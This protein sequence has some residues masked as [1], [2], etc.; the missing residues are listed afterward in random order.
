M[1]KDHLVST[2]QRVDVVLLSGDLAN[3][4]MENMTSLTT[5]ELE[6][7]HALVHKV[8]SE[9]LPISKHIYF[10]PGNH[11]VITTYSVSASMESP[12]NVHLRC[13]EIA[14]ALHL[15]GAGGSVPGYRNGAQC[16]D[17]FPYPSDEAFAADLT[18]ILDPVFMEEGA[19]SHTDAVILMTHNGP[20]Q[21]STTVA[22]ADPA[23]PVLSGSTALYKALCRQQLQQHVVLNI[24]G[25]T[26]DAPGSTRLGKTAI[27]NPGALVEE[28]YGLYTLSRQ[29]SRVAPAWKLSSITLLNLP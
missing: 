15:V 2:N 29:G 19:L 18:K 10:I 24:H 23:N 3:V 14:P 9:F 27:V 5:L 21:S 4:P 22:R 26:H 6:E 12:V 8:V 7:Q 16:W 17:S 28:R 13:V 1:L 11:D 20:D 25:H